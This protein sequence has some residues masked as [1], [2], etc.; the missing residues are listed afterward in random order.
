MAFNHQFVNPPKLI[1]TT[2]P[3][4]G[5]RVYK[6]PNGDMYQS[7][8]T[9]LSLLPNKALEN[10]KK[11]VGKVES[12]RVSKAATSR[13]SSLHSYIENYLLNEEIPFDNLLQKRLFQQTKKTLDAIDNIRLI[14]QPLY[15]DRLKL[16]G[17]PDCIGEYNKIFSII[18][19]KTSTRIKQE[20]WILSYYC[21]TAAYA[22]MF[23]ELYG[24]RPEQSVIIIAVEELNFPQVYIKDMD[25][26]VYLLKDYARKLNS[27]RSGVK[28]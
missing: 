10:W 3:E 13:G 9:F 25:E 27:Y 4:S 8:T 18:D 17:T 11:R 22:I 23:E 12:E 19:F 15:S 5:K 16:A 26:C 2:H 21:Q 20:D 14:E 28:S 6:T 24:T 7:V 1:Q